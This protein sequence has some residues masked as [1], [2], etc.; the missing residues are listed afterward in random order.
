MH[1]HRLTRIATL[2]LAIG[3]L[4]APTAIAQQDLRSPDAID[5]ATTVQTPQDLRSPDAIDAATTVQTPQDLRSPDTRD[6][7]DGR[8][9]YNTPEVVVVKAPATAPAG[10][11]DWADAGIGA[12]ALFGLILLGLGGALL[13][14]HRRQPPQAP[15]R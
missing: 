2:A 7:A 15:G 4:S 11:F 5:A 8:G 6:A 13:V 1:H 10:G 3:A 12:G 14:V 9:A